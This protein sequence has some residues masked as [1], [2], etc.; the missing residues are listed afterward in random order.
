[1]SAGSYAINDDGAAFNFTE[2]I[3]LGDTSSQSQN[4]LSTEGRV[5]GPVLYS[6]STTYQGGTAGD[7]AGTL[8]T[9]GA[10][11]VTA[12]GPGTTVIGQRSVELSVFR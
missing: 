1:M 8:T 2:S 7:L 9:T 6:E 4:S 5:D 11:S 3:F 10:P 12:G